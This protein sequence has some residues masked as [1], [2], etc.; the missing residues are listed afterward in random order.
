MNWAAAGASVVSYSSEVP[1]CE[2]YHVL[3]SDPSTIWLSEDGLP[4][5]LCISLKGLNVGLD[6][7]EI[8][9]IGWHCWHAY[10][11]NPCEIRIHV[12]KDGAKFRVWDTFRA[13]QCRRGVQLFCCV[14]IQ[15][16][17]H[18]FIAFEILSTFGG[19]QAYINRLFLYSEETAASS[20]LSS[21]PQG[22]AVDAGS[23]SMAESLTENLLDAKNGHEFSLISDLQHMLGLDDSVDPADALVTP[24]SMFGEELRSKPTWSDAMSS[25]SK[26]ESLASL[27]QSFSVLKPLQLKPLSLP[28]P[29]SARESE[30]E[31]QVR[32]RV[33][34][35]ERLE[36]LEQ[37]LSAIA[38]LLTLPSQR[39]QAD[40][41]PV[42]AEARPSA[43]ITSSPSSSSSSSSD[44]GG[45]S[46]EGKRMAPMGAQLAPLQAAPRSS[47]EATRRDCAH[48][49][50]RGHGAASLGAGPASLPAAQAI[51][52]R[53][54]VGG[55]QRRAPPAAATAADLHPMQPSA[56]VATIL[57]K[58]KL[59]ARGSAA[60]RQARGAE[61]G[62]GG[63]GGDIA[64]LV[65]ELH[66]AVL[67]K[68]IKEA[69]LALLAKKD[70]TRRR[71]VRSPFAR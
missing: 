30:S 28:A 61:T 13:E 47:Q 49:P 68:T 41:A 45:G 64:Q 46:G 31:E 1:G 18:P 51:V 4:Q 17:L 32:D 19:S 27:T 60:P 29:S 10:S 43:V 35:D 59:Q 38:S 69:Q 11:T 58:L 6:E 70:Q 53:L 62:A 36:H 63:A 48:H 12:S 2:A 25:K 15:A 20:F 54:R 42:P 8:R 9:S 71:R 40:S 34:N 67:Q 52:H 37:R 57:D 3:D 24:A 26:V 55:F 5:W 50:P 14:P 33:V 66:R 21:S 16:D 7:V 39:Q 56:R 65:G 23:D 22:L 44:G